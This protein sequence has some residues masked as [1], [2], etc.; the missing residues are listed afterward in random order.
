MN[1]VACFLPEALHSFDT[2]KIQYFA[3]AK[4]DF[5]VPGEEDRRNQVKSG[6]HLLPREGAFHQIQRFDWLATGKP[7]KFEQLFCL[8]GVSVDFQEKDQ[9]IDSKISPF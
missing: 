8:E 9:E 7:V 1:L 3:C 2:P 4:V 6:G 5:S